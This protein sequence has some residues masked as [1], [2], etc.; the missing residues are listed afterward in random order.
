VA[1]TR[2]VSRR[3]DPFFVRSIADALVLKD[4]DLFMVTDRSG[5]VPPADGHGFGLYLHA[6][7]FLSSLELDVAGVALAARATDDSRG[8]VALIELGNDVDIGLRE[9]NIVARQRLLVRL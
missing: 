3:R 5:N 1:R 6:C 8:N 7:R 4:R 9:G 2:T